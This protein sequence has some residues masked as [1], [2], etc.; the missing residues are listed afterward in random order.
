MAESV[1]AVAMAACMIVVAAQ[2][3]T[4]NTLKMDP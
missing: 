4:N 3:L 1:I 2:V